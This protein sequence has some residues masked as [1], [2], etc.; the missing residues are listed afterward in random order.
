MALVQQANVYAPAELQ[1]LWPFKI[2]LHY[3]KELYL[4]F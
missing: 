4:L 3:L 2:L 1:T